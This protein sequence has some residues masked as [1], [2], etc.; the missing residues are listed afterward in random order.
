MDGSTSFRVTVEY[1]I[2]LVVG[3]IEVSGKFSK[4][5]R[6][7]GATLGRRGRGRKF[8]S[9]TIVTVVGDARGF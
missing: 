6:R 3:G 5:N 7:D 4:R 9:M 8:L 2:E 1:I